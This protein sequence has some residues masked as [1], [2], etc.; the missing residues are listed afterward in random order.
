MK[1]LLRG[2]TLGLLC[3]LIHAKFGTAFSTQ[4]L[5]VRAPTPAAF[6]S[7]VPRERRRRALVLL[8]SIAIPDPSPGKLTLVKPPNLP[9]KWM[10]VSPTRVKATSS[11]SISPLLLVSNRHRH[12]HGTHTFRNDFLHFFYLSAMFFSSQ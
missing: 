11:P 2:P 6:R 10:P 4:G 7:P 3:F 5:A 9:F 12:R 8:Q 1:N